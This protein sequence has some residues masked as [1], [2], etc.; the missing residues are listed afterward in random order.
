MLLTYCTQSFSCFLQ[1]E[2]HDFDKLANRN[3]IKPLALLKP[4]IVV[5]APPMMIKNLEDPCLYE[6]TTH[7]VPHVHGC[8]CKCG[9]SA[10]MG[11]PFQK[12][13]VI[14]VFL[15]FILYK[16][17]HPSVFDP[18]D[19]FFSTFSCFGSFLFCWLIVQ[20]EHPLISNMRC[21]NVP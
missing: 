5:F 3:I 19:P 21:G 12:Y 8:M 6:D 9:V 14:L 17:G 20:R 13:G 4:P 1:K 7:Q 11:M 18:L 10:G 16:E 2:E 15:Y